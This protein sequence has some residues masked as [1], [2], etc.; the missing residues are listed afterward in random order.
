MGAMTPLFT[1]A[2][3]PA[4][5]PSSS[6]CP[7]PS[8][9]SCIP[10]GYSRNHRASINSTGLRHHP[11]SLTESLLAASHH[12]TGPGTLR[13]AASPVQL[14]AFVRERQ[15]PGP[16]QDPHRFCRAATSPATQTNP[17]RA[18]YCESGLLHPSSYRIGVE[19]TG[20]I[21]GNDKVRLHCPPHRAPA[22]ILAN[23]ILN[24]DLAVEVSRRTG[25]S[26]R[27]SPSTSPAPPSRSLCRP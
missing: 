10:S 1:L 15:A 26:L 9:Y 22:C 11:L 2:I 3:S 27:A 23:V 8:R 20:F 5:D 24:L 17:K 19:P 7:I 12:R 18:P 25:G 13:S 16:G 6:S 21:F 4:R 14:P